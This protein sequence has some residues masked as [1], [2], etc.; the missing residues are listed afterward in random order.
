MGVGAGLERS[1]PHV[2]PHSSPDGHD[3][4]SRTEQHP[5]FGV[6]DAAVIVADLDSA[7]PFKQRQET[8]L[9]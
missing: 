7:R 6:I 5:V 9:L 1:E 8:D 2:T 3:S 4:S